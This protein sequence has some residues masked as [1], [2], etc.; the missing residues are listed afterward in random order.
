MMFVVVMLGFI[1]EAQT[2]SETIGTYKR[3][4]MEMV[5]IFTSTSRSSSVRSPP[6]D[7]D[8]QPKKCIKIEFGFGLKLYFSPDTIYISC[9]KRRRLNFGLE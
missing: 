8:P 5:A 2:E 9:N 4:I 1:T 7:V 3:S 6:S